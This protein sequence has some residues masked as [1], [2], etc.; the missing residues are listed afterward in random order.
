MLNQYSSDFFLKYEQIGK[1]FQAFGLL[2]KNKEAKA[3]NETLGK[4]DKLGN[5]RKC[6]RKKKR[7]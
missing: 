5:K 3:N 6:E 4:R 1:N 7:N 2:I